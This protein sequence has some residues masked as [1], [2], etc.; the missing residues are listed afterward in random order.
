[1]PEA[2][3][4]LET[5]VDASAHHDLLYIKVALVLAVLTAMEV[6]WPYIV[7]A[8]W[9]DTALV[10]MS[11]LLILMMIKFVIIAS[12]FMHLRF[13]SKILSQV[14]YVGLILAVAVYLAALLTFDTFR[15]W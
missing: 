10:L 2:T 7:E 4:T 12:V 14:F 8:V 9:D 3:S 15:A 5:D 6:A 1:M 13:D 11:P